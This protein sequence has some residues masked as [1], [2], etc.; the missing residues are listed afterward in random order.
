MACV[1]T[2]RS[3]PMKC[4]LIEVLP[5]TAQGTTNYSEQRL[6]VAENVHALCYYAK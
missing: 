6:E 3:Y 5:T 2:A 1:N 4:L